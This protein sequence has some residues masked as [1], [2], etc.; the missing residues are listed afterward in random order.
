MSIAR[1]RRL[2]RAALAATTTATAAVGLMAPQAHAQDEPPRAVA[3][4]PVSAEADSQTRTL[5]ASDPQA[6]LAASNLCGPGYSLILAERLPDDRRFGTLFV[7]AADGGLAGGWNCT[8]FDNNLGSPKHMKL[9]MCE[10]RVRNPRCDVDEGTFSQY[11]G[12]VYMDNCPKTTAI[13][14]SGGYRIIDAVR[15]SLCN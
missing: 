12:P 3:N 14:W 10:N 8:V 9:K 1:C 7:Y 6:A 2:I 5:V 13:M 15:G 4:V 11:A